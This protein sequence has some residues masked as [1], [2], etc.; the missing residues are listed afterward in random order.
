LRVNINGKEVN[1]E[2]LAGSGMDDFIKQATS[3]FNPFGG[4]FG[5]FGFGGFSHNSDS[6]TVNIEVNID[7]HIRQEIVQ[8]NF[9]G[10][11]REF[12][13]LCADIAKKTTPCSVKFT[14]VDKIP[15][16]EKDK[17]LLGVNDDYKVIENYVEFKNNVW[18]N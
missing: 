12:K 11:Y 1:I 17:V 16:S 15:L 5:G 18:K 14:V 10:A 2:D 6:K 7:G 8:A 9:Q 13:I 4:G 3:G